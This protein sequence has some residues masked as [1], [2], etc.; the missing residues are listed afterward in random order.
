[1]G[2]IRIPPTVLATMTLLV[3]FVLTRLMLFGRQTALAQ[4]DD[5]YTTIQVCDLAYFRHPPASV[6]LRCLRY[7]LKYI[8][9]R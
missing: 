3:A 9:Q 6:Y 5:L 8:Y 2:V 4:S 1:M 7:L